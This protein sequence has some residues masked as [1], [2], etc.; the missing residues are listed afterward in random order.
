MVHL[1][2]VAAVSSNFALGKDNKLVLTHKE[3]SQHFKNLT[4]GHC[5]IMGRKT[6]QSL[7]DGPLSDRRNVVISR[8]ADWVKPEEIDYSTPHLTILNN[9]V[10]IIHD[11]EYYLWQLRETRCSQNKFFVIG[12]GEI[13]ETFLKNNMINEMEITFWDKEVEG[14]VFFPIHYLEDF[15]LISTT[16]P[17]TSTEFKFFHFKHKKHGI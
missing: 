12:G 8:K 5:V 2:L 14:D 10:T 9:G 11:L 17:L 6:Y 13:Y 3:D 4:K 15:E 1:I 16:D 7:P